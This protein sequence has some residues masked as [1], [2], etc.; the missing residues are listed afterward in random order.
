M[1]EYVDHSVSEEV[2]IIGRYEKLR[3]TSVFLE[4]LKNGDN[5]LPG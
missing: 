2:E 5:E 1:T 4:A 3:D